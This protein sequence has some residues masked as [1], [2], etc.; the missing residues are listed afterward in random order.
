GG[1]FS[2]PALASG[3]YAIAVESRGFKKAEVHAIKLDVGVPTD[4]QVKLEVGS[5]A[6]TVTV[7]GEGAMLQTQTATVSTT[8]QG[9]QIIELPMVSREALD[10][11][12]YLPGITTPGRPR[13]STVDGISKSAI[14]ITLDGINVQDNNGKSTDGF[15]TYVRPRLDAVEEVTVSTGTAGADNTGEGAVQIKFITRSG[16]NQYHGSLYEYHR[17]PSLNANYWFI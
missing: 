3:N 10:L 15:Y 11:A 14:N 13:T 4:I 1:T 12:L 8:L 6:E 17:K 9:R 5:Q 2:V 7:Q 16:S